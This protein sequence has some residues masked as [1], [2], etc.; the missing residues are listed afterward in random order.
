MARAFATEH[1]EIMVSQGDVLDAI[2]Y[3]LK[4]MDQPT[5]DGLNTYLISRQT[6]AAG[7][8]VALS[9]LGGDELF[10]GYSTFRDVPRMERF[11]NSGDDGRRS[12][13]GPLTR[14]F[15]SLASDTDQEPEA[16]GARRRARRRIHPYFLARALFTPEQRECFV[17]VGGRSSLARANAP[18]QESLQHARELIRSIVFPIWKR[19][20]TC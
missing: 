15:A 9:G 8:K 12:C 18:L 4:A 7:I 5:I 10:A 13:A 14:M 16:R 17:G 20:A 1:Q 6:R 19:A 3:A 11:A 2:P